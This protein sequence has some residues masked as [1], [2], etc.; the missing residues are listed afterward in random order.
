M[1]KALEASSIAEALIGLCADDRALLQWETFLTL[2]SKALEADKTL[3][4][5]VNNPFSDESLL[6]KALE[7]A[8]SAN[9]SQKKFLDYLASEK[10]FALL[11]AITKAFITGIEA[12]QKKLHIT[13]ESA[14]PL[15]PLEQ[16][17][18]LAKLQEDT[19]KTVLLNFH[20]RPELLAGLRLSSIDFVWDNSLYHKM[21]QLAEHILS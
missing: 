7:K 3:M 18:L 1:N 19:G 21:N 2:I 13:V 4:A 12:K 11:P 8:L 5:F 17:Q 10:T 14:T 20:S 16:N 15:T 9:A 6:S